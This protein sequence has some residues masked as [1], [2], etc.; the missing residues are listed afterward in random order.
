M[1]KNQ[2]EEVTNIMVVI[3]ESK[4]IVLMIFY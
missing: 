2:L 3:A 1:E 4:N